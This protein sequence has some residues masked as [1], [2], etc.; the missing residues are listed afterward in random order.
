MF[1]DMLLLSSWAKLDNI[2][3]AIK[4]ALERKRKVIVQG[5]QIAYDTLVRLYGKEGQELIDAV[6]AEHEL[7]QKLT[8]SGMTFE[9]ISELA[10]GGNEINQ[11]S[12]FDK[13]PNPYSD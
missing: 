12:F 1:S 11:T 10:D 4:E 13:K 2:D 5:K 7:I 6:T 9:Q 3:K 8:A